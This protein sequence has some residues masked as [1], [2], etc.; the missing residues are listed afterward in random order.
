MIFSSEVAREQFHKLPTEVQVTYARLEEY[1][2]NTGKYLQCHAVTTDHKTK[3]DVLVC[4]SEKLYYP[5]S[6]TD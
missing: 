1:L 6:T 3:L 2:A 4:I 5:A